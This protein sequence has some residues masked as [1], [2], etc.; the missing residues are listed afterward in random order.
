MFMRQTIGWIG[1]AALIFVAGCQTNSERAI[2]MQRNSGRM[3]HS[4]STGWRAVCKTQTEGGHP[5]TWTG[6]YWQDKE[7]AMRDAL[8]HNRQ[9]PGHQAVVEQ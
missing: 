4:A 3:G 1:L 9:N 7:V 6:P 2:K 8:E 5:G